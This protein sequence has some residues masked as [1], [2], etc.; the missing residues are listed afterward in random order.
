MSSVTKESE[1]YFKKCSSCDFIWSSRE[2]FLEDPKIEG[3]GYQSFDQQLELGRFLFNHLVCETTLALKVKNFLD[4][5]EGPK[6]SQK[7]VG[8]DECPGHCLDKNNLEPC[9]EKCEGAYVREI[10]QKLLNRNKSE[11]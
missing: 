6:H 8:S 9:F 11:K 10:L 7:L 1:N 2:E 3:I 4:F 5:Y